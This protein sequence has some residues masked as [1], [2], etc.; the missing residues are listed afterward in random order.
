MDP[1]A[2]V[3]YPSP[4]RSW[5]WD[6]HVSRP[7]PGMIRRSSSNADIPAAV[8]ATER[9][10]FLHPE[11]DGM[12]IAFLVALLLTGGGQAGGPEFLVSLEYPGDYD[13]L[14]CRA[15]GFPDSLLPAGCSSLDLHLT[16]LPDSVQCLAAASTPGGWLLL[17]T[18]RASGFPWGNRNA[19][20]HWDSEEGVL[21]LATQM[22]MS[23]RFF[24]A[25]WAPG[26]DGFTFVRVWEEDPSQAALGRTISLLDSGRVEEAAAS[27]LGIMYPA[28]YYEGGRMAAAF[29]LASD[30]EARRR[31]ALCDWEGAYE[32]YFCAG[33]AYRLC[34]LDAEWF[35][36]ADSLGNAGNPL[37]DWISSACLA[38]ILDHL[39]ATALETGHE[40]VAGEAALAAEALRDHSD[41]PD[42]TGTDTVNRT[43]D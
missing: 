33:D 35:L 19:S 10:A 41:S 18:L 28:S 26:A 22:P 27:L 38:G 6:A 29:L 31:A 3:H 40:L 8:K 43:R 34:G 17:D 7:A 14:T 25:S 32:V 36:D 11:G 42:A 5:S 24:F 16:F 20:A 37:E 23:M 1:P 13:G 2:D 12:G 21:V 30:S 9:S 39:G 15:E 4:V